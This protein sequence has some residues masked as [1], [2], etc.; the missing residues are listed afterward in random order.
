MRADK[1]RNPG[2]QVLR[3][4]L[5]WKERE[6][7]LPK[8]GELKVWLFL[9]RNLMQCTPRKSMIEASELQGDIANMLYTG[10]TKA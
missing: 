5:G 2:V 10:W 1:V 6:R 8:L 9:V 3:M 4:M 7:V